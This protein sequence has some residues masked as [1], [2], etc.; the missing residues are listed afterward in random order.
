LSHKSQV[1]WILGKTGLTHKTK[2]TGFL[3]L[4][5]RMKSRFLVQ[6]PGFFLRKFWIL[7]KILALL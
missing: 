6:K 1:F 4:I 3:A 5:L 7:G 2:E